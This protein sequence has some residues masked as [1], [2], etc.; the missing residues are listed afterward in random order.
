MADLNRIIKYTNRDFNTIRNSLI[1]YS[2]TYFPNTYNDFS[3]SSTGMLFIEMTAYVGDV[4]SFYLDNQI[5]ETFIQYAQQNSNVYNLAYMMGYKPKVT[6]VATATI[7]FYQQVPSKTSGTGG[8]VPDFDYA[9]KIPANAQITSD[10]NSQIKFIV[11]DEVDFSVSS[12]LNPTTVSVY[13]LTGTEPNMWLLKK[14]RKAISGAI[15]TTPLVFTSPQR[16]NTRQIAA[17][18]IVGVLDVTDSNGNKWYE[19]DNLAQDSVFNTIA[20]TPANDPNAVQ[21][22]TPNI[23]SVKRT[24]RRFTTR[25]LSQNVLQ[26]E[27]GAGTVSDND[28]NI[29]P[30][31]DNVGLG[32]PFS[33][34]RLTTAF[35]PLNFM[36]TDTYGIAPSNTTLTVRYITGG[37]LAANVDA[38]DLTS[39]DTSG[40]VFVN[41]NLTDATAQTVF[42]SVAVTNDAA[43]DGG[44]DG[45]TIEE[46]RQNALGNF[47]NQ[48]RTVTQQDYLIRALSMPSNLGTIAKAHIQPTVIG[49][50]EAGTI[51]SILDM[52][53]LSYDSNKKL[54]TASATLKQNLKTYLAEY[55][56]I[57]D[58]ITI[59]DAYI[60]NIGIEFDIMVLPNFNNNTVL[61]DCI[62]ALKNYF[63][64]DKWNLNMPIVYKHLYILL[65]KVEGVQTVKNVQITNKA[66]TSLGYSD[67]AY[68]MEGAT[69]NDIIYP[70]IDPMVFELKYPNSDIIGRVVGF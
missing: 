21:D 38:D 3:K 1:D 67:F 48:L 54:R 28:E 63:E 29:V 26:L 55:R 9:L 59:K 45:D 33:K 11:E 57:G 13:S 27:F 47:Q 31:P 15:I 22:D 49:E 19:V 12:S 23:L 36:F 42:D 14:T 5:Q 20:N 60:I 35:S 43:A 61:T 17:S 25:F 10:S 30:N 68:D 6:T 37:G 69:I 53:V 7:T 51:P 58:A 56:M 65:D 39:L 18:N 70:S 52:Y 4:L 34:D 2:K 24:Q 50:Y 44:Q 16:F 46:I 40:M 66:G 41:P 62:E 64:I 8:K 32:L